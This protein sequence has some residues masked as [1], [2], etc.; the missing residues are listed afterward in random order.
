MKTELDKSEGKK[1]A[2]RRTFL[3]TS[4]S[5]SLVFWLNG[6]EVLLSPAEARQQALPFSILQP[7]EVQTLD[8][9]G[10]ILH[11]GARDA[12]IS[13]F[14][15]QQLGLPIRDS[16]LIAKHF[17]APPYLDFYRNG[18]RAMDE[19]CVDKFGS[20][21]T[22][23]SRA[24][25]Q[26]AVTLIRDGNPDAWPGSGSNELQAPPAP[27]LYLVVRG[28][29]VDVVYAGFDDY[30]KLGVPYMAHILPPAKW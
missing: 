18:L 6:A 27:L 29:A 28:D 21:I 12:G 13:H 15:D 9:L 19:F 1:P 17:I 11:P 14:V 10:E 20:D 24:D 7:A 3:K 16:L 8:T 26:A 22:S 4:S 5:A 2:S 30:E 23:L 25:A